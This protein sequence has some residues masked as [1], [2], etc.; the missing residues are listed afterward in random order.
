PLPHCQACKRLAAPLSCCCCF[1]WHTWRSCSFPVTTQ[2]SLTTAGRAHCSCTRL[3]VERPL[4]AVVTQVLRLLQQP[5][6]AAAAARHG[7]PAAGGSRQAHARQ[8]HQERH[9]GRE[10]AH[11]TSKLA[12]RLRSEDACQALA[13]WSVLCQQLGPCPA[14]YQR[15]M[16]CRNIGRPSRSIV[17]PLS[18]FPDAATMGIRYCRQDLRQATLSVKPGIPTCY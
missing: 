7:P 10:F 9:R 18:C 16:R 5:L 8:P 4:P 6:A 2:R 3:Q 12:V 14:H 11:T 17:P 1:S 15:R 13:V